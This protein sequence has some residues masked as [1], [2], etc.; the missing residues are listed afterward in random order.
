M[1]ATLGTAD[2]I[3]KEVYEPRIQ[4]LLNDDAPL[5]Q[6]IDSS[7]EG[8]QRETGMLGG[9][10]V[11]FAIHVSRNTGIGARKEAEDLPTPGN[12][13]YQVA[14]VNLTYLY[15]VVQATGQLEELASGGADSFINALTDEVDRIAI[16]LSVD[17]NRQL[18]GDGT[19]KLGATNTTGAQ[20]TVTLITASDTRNFQIGEYVDVFTSA[21]FASNV[22]GTPAA[23]KGSTYV[24]AIDSVA[25]T[26]T[27][28]TSITYAAGDV[29]VRNGSVAREV[30]GL[31]A[32]INSTGTLYNV[33]PTTQPL[34]ASTVDANGGTPRA[35]SE[36]LM[37]LQTHRVRA[38]GSKTTDIF[39]GLGVSRAY[40]N[41]L[42][43]QRMVVNT[44]EVKGG[45]SGMSFATTTGG[46][47][48]HEDWT[49]PPGTMWGLNT[50]EL[51][52]FHENNW[53][54]LERDGKMW[55]RIYGTNGIG[56][57]MKSATMYRYLQ[58]ATKRRNAHWVIKDVIEG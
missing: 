56:K 47:P 7:S 49:A 31:A 20:T 41:L 52:F 38:F 35:I 43:Q 5:V 32:I 3:L 58:L 54:W 40:Q 48:L 10:Y 57:D 16:D 33:N 30:I 13:G 51:T 46:I 42:Q 2:A 23:A 25:G 53:G 45:T 18:W 28:S 27:F 44:T 26:V 22:S 11:K 12:Q 24:T 34:W 6:V 4:R 21:N 19:G 37:T 9:R 50:R 14:Q 17:L 36:G 1:P 15:G 29:F 8:V 39:M 55:Q